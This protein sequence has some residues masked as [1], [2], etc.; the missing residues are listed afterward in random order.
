MRTVVDEDDDDDVPV[1]PTTGIRTILII[2]NNV[3]Q[4]FTVTIFNDFFFCFPQRRLRRRRR[5][6]RRL[7]K[8]S[9]YFPVFLVVVWFRFLFEEFAIHRNRYFLWMVLQLGWPWRG[10]CFCFELLLLFHRPSPGGSWWSINSLL[11]QQE[12]NYKQLN[13]LFSGGTQP[14]RVKIYSY[15]FAE[16]SRCELR[17]LATLAQLRKRSVWRWVHKSENN[18]SFPAPRPSSVFLP[19][20][21]HFPCIRTI[22]FHRYDSQTV[23]AHTRHRMRKAKEFLVFVYSISIQMMALCWFVVCVRAEKEIYWISTT[24]TTNG[25]TASSQL[26]ERSLFPLHPL[27][28]QAECECVCVRRQTS[29]INKMWNSPDGEDPILLLSHLC[30]IKVM[31]DHHRLTVDDD[32]E[33]AYCRLSTFCLSSFFISST[34]NPLTRIAH[35]NRHRRRDT[36]SHTTLTCLT[37]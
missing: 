4:R 37:I 29:N 34:F 7:R 31:A 18:K 21:M 2:R 35:N 20:K 26:N 24:T 5:H 8:C 9:K 30:V 16:C 36:H 10:C 3:A 14:Q 23:C 22:P 1:L 32:D 13:Y 25:N 28:E 17:E 11:P 6:R 19:M 27:T 12:P 33:D 15:L